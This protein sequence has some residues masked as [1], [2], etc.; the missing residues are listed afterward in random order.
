MKS[1]TIY[2]FLAT[3]FLLLCFAFLA[4]AQ[5][6]TIVGTVTD[7]SGAPV[8]NVN[9][10]ITNT[11][12]AIVRHITTNNVGQYVAPDVHIG[13]YSARAEASG[14]KVAEQKDINLNVG[15]RA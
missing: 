15:D 8:P 14:F 11:E 4:S 7:P 3:G 9:I 12:T 1:N 2:R 6:A 5:E 13:H 10:T